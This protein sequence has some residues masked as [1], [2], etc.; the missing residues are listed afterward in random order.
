MSLDDILEDFYYNDITL[1]ILN[2]EIFNKTE[3]ARKIISKFLSIR[4]T[5]QKSD[6]FLCGIH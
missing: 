3:E 4:F 6:I 2:K 1:D 5:D